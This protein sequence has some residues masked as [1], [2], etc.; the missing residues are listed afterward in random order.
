MPEFAGYKDMDACIA[1]NGDKSDP[2]AFC[3]TLMDQ[4]EKAAKADRAKQFVIKASNDEQ[5]IVFGWA[6]VAVKADGEQLVDLQDDVIE[7]A[8]LEKAA[9]DF[10][11]FSRSADEMHNGRPIGQMIESFL[12]TPEKRK[13]MGL[14]VTKDVRWW[15]GFKLSP[16]AY[17]KVKDGT[18]K[19]LSIEGGATPV[20]V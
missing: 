4:A 2:Q 20:E 19:M 12:D 15:V 11:L 8:E 18:Y 16:E 5:N 3:S 6:S 1:A 9:Y 17:A 10:M 13:A 14:P 7:P